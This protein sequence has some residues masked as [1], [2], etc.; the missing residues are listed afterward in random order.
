[1]DKIRILIVDDEASLRLGVKSILA[2]EGYEVEEAQT[3]EDAIEKIRAAAPHLVLQDV[4]MGAGMKGFD[5]CRRIK[6]NPRTRQIAVIMLTA[7]S[8]KGTVV[9]CLDAGA[10]DYL[11]KPYDSVRL[12]EKVRKILS[13][14]IQSLEAGT[15]VLEDEN[16][17]A[18]TR[19]R[20]SG[21]AAVRTAAETNSESAGEEASAGSESDKPP[22]KHKKPVS[23]V[24]RT[25][26]R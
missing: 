19:R 9:E 10:D 3:G 26:R 17:E 11:L 4:N 2:D 24:M 23:S 22:M 21:L 1:M 8:E 13:K 25:K 14:R 20:G 6:A 12:L 5:V 16:V 7:D 15:D 18:P